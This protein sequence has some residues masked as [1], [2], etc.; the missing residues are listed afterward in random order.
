M[1]KIK[2][3]ADLERAR[4]RNNIILGVVMIFLLVVSTGGYSLMSADSDD[5]NVVEENGFEFVRD[6]G[7]WKLV[8]DS[9]LDSPLDSKH[10]AG[11]GRH[12]TGQGVVFGFMYLPSE[13][14]DVDVNVSVEFGD[15]AGKP[16]Y[17]VNPGEGVGEVLNNLGGY[18][19]RYQESCLQQGFEDVGSQSS[20]N[21]TL[22][23]PGPGVGDLGNVSMENNESVVDEVNCTGDLPVKDCD[24]NLIIFEVGNETRVYGEKN[25]VFIEGDFIR[26]IDAFLYEVLGIR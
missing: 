20:M 11:Q 21:M 19:L 5:A 15:Y 22:V 16:L 9:Q 23:S 8:F 6:G 25:C 2:T 12:Q 14:G 7:M 17:F 3:V 18:I 13:V 26:G 10:Q 24:S 1:R 4:R